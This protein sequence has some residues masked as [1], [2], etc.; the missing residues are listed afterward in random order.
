MFFRLSR[1]LPLI[2]LASLPARAGSVPITSLARSGNEILGV[3]V[4]G[5]S[6]GQ[7]RLQNGTVTAFAGASP[8]V[9]LAPF[10][11]S[12]T[13]GAAANGYL[14]D[15]LFDT[16]LINPA[17]GATAV[18]LTFSP[19]LVNRPGADFVVMEINAAAPADGFQARINGVTVQVTAGEYGNTGVSTSAANV[20]NTRN[21][22]N[23]GNIT[24]TTLA[25]LNAAPLALGSSNTTQAVF[26]VALDLSDF[27]VAAGASV[28]TIQ[29]GSAATGLTF[30]PVFVAGI[31]PPPEVTS[32]P[33]ISGFLADNGDGIEDE[34]GDTPDWIELYNGTAAMVSVAGW[35]LTDDA[36]MPMKWTLPAGTT[37][38][39][40][41]YRVVFA[42]G[43]NRV[44]PQLHT[45]FQLAKTSGYLAL[46]RPGGSIA[47]AYTYGAQSED[48]SFGIKGAALTAG[49]LATPTPGSANVGA[50]SANGP[51]PTIVFGAESGVFTS[52]V[53]L[54]MSLPAGT[55][56]DAAVHFTTDLSEPTEASP[57]YSAPL[58]IVAS[59]T[60]RAR[61]F[62]P[63]HLPGDI[64]NRHFIQLGSDV[65]ANYRGTGAPF[66]ST[67]P[68]LLLDSF[69]T[70]VDGDI[71][72]A[73]PY[74]TTLA[75]LYDT[76]GGVASLA[77]AP[78]LVKR[79]G[80]HVRGQSSASFPQHRY[81]WELWRPHQDKD[82]A[83][84]LLGMPAG[85]G[86]VLHAP[87]NDKTLLRNAFA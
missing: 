83:A 62:Q 58:S 38:Q 39:P 85:A 80:T 66:E 53:P 3:T 9:V 86:W 81:A 34:D 49:F 26:G 20:L 14:S 61:V 27:G 87:W 45:N 15:Y 25:G 46:V 23:T 63:G 40:Y 31:V 41:E 75:A 52:T 51:A 33:I 19:A 71:S 10:G 47:S 18:T 44:A 29:L 22:G 48:V 36:A 78:T 30:D 79:G 69:S 57:T 24:V 50:Q 11:V 76:A 43:K 68:V 65:A 54:A 28:A 73:A 37:L 70:N 84:S 82:D 1:F 17:I 64:G 72:Q 59:T 6:L 67:M 74:R 77:A 56:G 21:A 35:S 60:I 42:S 16:G 2:L 8:S 32:G 7:N 5:A 12:P 13:V 4:N 55:P